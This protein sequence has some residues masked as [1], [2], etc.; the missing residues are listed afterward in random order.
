[1]N[2]DQR[3]LVGEFYEKTMHLTEQAKV[4]GK[5]GA[6]IGIKGAKLGLS[7]IFKVFHLL[8]PNYDTDDLER[9]ME[10]EASVI[11]DQ[12]KD[13]ERYAD[14]IEDSAEEVEDLAEEMSEKIPEI[15]RLGWF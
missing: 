5:E 8:S 14:S 9:E 1:M 15:D 11:E 4:I 2:A 10:A 3:Q 12:A 13:L 7:A 6:R